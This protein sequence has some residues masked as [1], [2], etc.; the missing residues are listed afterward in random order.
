MVAGTEPKDFTPSALIVDGAAAGEDEI[1]ADASSME[2]KVTAEPGEERVETIETGETCETRQTLFYSPDIA[3]GDADPILYGDALA[4]GT[5]PTGV[6][7]MGRIWG[8]GSRRL[9]PRRWG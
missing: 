2:P 3:A 6:G 1:G 4:Q 8:G 5:R 7:E 9:R